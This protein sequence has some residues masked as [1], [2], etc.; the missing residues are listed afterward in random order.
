[1]TKAEAARITLGT[2][3]YDLA[4]PQTWLDQT[5]EK[6]KEL[7]DY[8]EILDSLVWFYP[9]GDPFGRPCAITAEGNEILKVINSLVREPFRFPLTERPADRTREGLDILAFD[10]HYL[11]GRR[12]SSDTWV[13]MLT[14][15]MHDAPL[16]AAYLIA[17][18]TDLFV[19]EYRTA[20]VQSLA[21]L[22]EEMP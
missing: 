3:T 18:A 4:L 13:T 21:N 6:L 15:L 9:E 2:Q 1:M 20:F 7:W 8:E 16:C 5:A 14:D 11:F 19:G 10:L 22:V 12:N 17:K